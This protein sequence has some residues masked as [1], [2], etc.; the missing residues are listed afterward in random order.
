[1]DYAREELVAL[2]DLPQSLGYARAR[3]TP[4][5]TPAPLPALQEG[6]QY[7]AAQLASSD[8]T[9]NVRAEPCL[10]YTSIKRKGRV[11]VICENPKHKQKQG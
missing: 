4:K 6:E 8:S 7:A 5:P 3:P 2:P 9:L 11:M 1:M 10:L